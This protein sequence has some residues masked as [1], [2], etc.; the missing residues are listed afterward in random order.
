MKKEKLQHDQNQQKSLSGL[1]SGG[2]Y[3]EKKIEPAKKKGKK[4]QE[5]PAPKETSLP[6]FDISNPQTFFDIEIG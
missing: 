4:D 5:D 6:D 1:F 3:N 2:L